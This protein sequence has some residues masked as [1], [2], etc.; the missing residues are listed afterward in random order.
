MKNLKEIMKN[1]KEKMYELKIPTCDTIKHIVCYG[2][3]TL[4]GVLPLCL[5][6]VEKDPEKYTFINKEEDSDYKNMWVSYVDRERECLINVNGNKV[7]LED[8]K[9]LLLSENDKK[10]R[11]LQLSAYIDGNEKWKTMPYD[12]ELLKESFQQTEYREYLEKAS[13][14]GDGLEHRL[15][16]VKKS[17]NDEL[18]KEIRDKK[19]I[20]VEQYSSLREKIND[21]DKKTN[22]VTESIERVK[23]KEEN[24]KVELQKNQE[25][26]DELNVKIQ[27]CGIFQGKQKKELNEQLQTIGLRK[28]GEIA[29]EQKRLS[30]EIIKN[31]EEKR[32]LDETKVKLEAEN[33]FV[34]VLIADIEGLDREDFERVKELWDRIN[35]FDSLLS[36]HV[37][38][39]LLKYKEKRERELQELRME[40]IKNNP[41]KVVNITAPCSGEIFEIEKKMGDRI[42]KGEPILVIKALEMEIPQVS[43]T[44]GIIV[45][46]CVR[47]GDHFDTNR[48]LAKV[49]PE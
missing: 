46:I 21:I 44:N 49:F 41:D 47:K 2:L 38:G 16:S 35:D 19:A 32:S 7:S 31:D 48:I 12:M 34:E 42:K 43:S 45:D 23:I 8:F 37:D 39:E 20:F 15:H 22:S 36:R 9:K 4:V 18:V 11:R 24:L 6:D 27:K 17:M 14:T 29:D 28:Q 1:L 30:R 25:Y 3:R 5:N 40:I 33:S 26:I 10:F 13:D